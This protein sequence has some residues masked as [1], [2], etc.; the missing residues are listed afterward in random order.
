MF[1]GASCAIVTP[2][3]NGAVDG[4]ALR[5]LARHLVAGGLD[6]LVVIG[7]TGEGATLT[8][9][10]KRRA[11]EIVLAEARGRA[12]VVAG[13]GTNST[14]QTVELSRAAREAGADG[15]MVVT[16]YYNKPT[17]DGLVRHYEAVARA[18]A[19][20]IIVYN[21]PGRT[22]LNLTPATAARLARIEHV[23]A[24]K[25]AAGSVDQAS[26]LVAQT[27]LT[28]LA[29]D[30]SLTLPM[31]AVGAKGIVS[32]VANVAPREVKALVVAAA[33]SDLAA[34]RA[35]HARLY[36]LTK[37]MF[38]ETN[39]GPVKHA[40]HLLGFIADELRLPLVPVSTENGR[41]I[42]EALRTFGLLAGTGAGT[43]S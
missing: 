4:E 2:F 13:T 6:G 19:L 32:V 17:P 1:E 8:P 37:A 26:E 42:E 12:F 31:M 30:D 22:G 15:V 11:L 33:R 14:Q 5:S 27:N 29:G 24:I 28:V 21:V 16:P 7:S 35:L 41:A 9:D 38:I 10:E 3:K 20:P 34:A 39:P 40:L 18:S 43:R 23:V 36:P 25:E